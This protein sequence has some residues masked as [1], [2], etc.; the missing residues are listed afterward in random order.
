MGLDMYLIRKKKDVKKEEEKVKEINWSEVDEIAYWRKANQVHKWFVENVQDGTDD[1]GYY[2][3]TQD[4][5]QQLVDIC[6]EILRQ[7]ELIDGKVLLADYHQSKD[8]K[9]EH[10]KEYGIGKVIDKPEICEQLLPTQSG[11]FFGG[12][13]YDEWYY[14]DIRRTR[15]RLQAIIDLLEWN[16]YE[17]YYGSSW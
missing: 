15:D 14:E 16:L 4:K 6:N 5:L 1:C 11:F 10:I 3:V 13:E 12:T 9:S 8:G 2:K 7:V 17:V